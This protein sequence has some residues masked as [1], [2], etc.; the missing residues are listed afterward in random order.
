MLVSGQ[1]FTSVVL[2]GNCADRADSMGLL[3]APPDGAREKNESFFVGGDSISL[4][5][6]AR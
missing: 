3:R 1:K 2:F 6:L 5:Q 4:M